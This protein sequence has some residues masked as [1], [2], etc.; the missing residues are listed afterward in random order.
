MK[1]LKKS[2]LH[3]T[4]I[5]LL[6]RQVYR[7]NYSV[8]ALLRKVKVIGTGLYFSGKKYAVFQI[9]QSFNK[10]IENYFVRSLHLSCLSSCLP[11]LE[12]NAKIQQI[13]PTQSKFQMSLD[14]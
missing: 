2:L 10:H 5:R 3:A 14:L 7:T 11:F 12:R 4:E 13:K 6:Y 1:V 9:M 8:K